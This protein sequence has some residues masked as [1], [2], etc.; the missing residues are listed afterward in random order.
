MTISSDFYTP[1]PVGSHIACELHEESK[2][3]N[4]ISLSQLHFK[5]VDNHQT[6]TCKSTSKEHA[7]SLPCH[8]DT[9]TSSYMDRLDKGRK[10]V[11]R[12]AKINE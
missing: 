3:V 9:P 6:I 1:P 5:L 4:L 7:I 12:E 8:L 11:V 10:E 2:H